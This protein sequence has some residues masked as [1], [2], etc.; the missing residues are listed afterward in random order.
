MVPIS[1]LTQ[2]STLEFNLYALTCTEKKI[3]VGYAEIPLFNDAGMWICGYKYVNLWPAIYVDKVKG[4][5]LGSFPG[6]TQ[7]HVEELCTIMIGLP[8]FNSL[9][10]YGNKKIREFENPM[11]GD[12]DYI[13]HKQG[14]IDK[15]LKESVY[16]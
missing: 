14:L 12:E 7:D 9:M 16:H 13:Y 2:E 1:E 3:L 4:R 15:V 8:E 10:V 11:E 5:C 6:M